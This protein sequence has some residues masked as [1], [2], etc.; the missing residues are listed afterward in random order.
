MLLNLQVCCLGAV[1][2]TCWM[3]EA[4]IAGYWAATSH[5]RSDII[6]KP[7]VVWNAATF[8]V[9]GLTTAFLMGLF[10]KVNARALPIQNPNRTINHVLVPIVMLGILSAFCE[11]LIDQYFGPLDKR[12]RFVSSLICNERGKRSQ[13]VVIT[14]SFSKI[15][16]FTC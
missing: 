15:N 12:I 5:D 14:H 4:A 8:T 10:M 13:K 7:N 9:R 2:F 1:G 6:D 11:S 3:V 16:L